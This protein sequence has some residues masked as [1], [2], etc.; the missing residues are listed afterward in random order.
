VPGGRVEPPEDFIIGALREMKEEGG[1]DVIFF[2]KNFMI[3]YNK[4]DFF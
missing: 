3:E 4:N 1:I 2:K